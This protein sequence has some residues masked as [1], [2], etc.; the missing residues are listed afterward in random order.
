MF[1]TFLW[2]HSNSK[3]VSYVSWQNR[4]PNL[5]TNCNIKLIVRVIASELLECVWPFVVL[6]LKGW[7]WALQPCVMYMQCIWQI[8][9]FQTFFYFR[10]ALAVIHFSG[11]VTISRGFFQWSSFFKDA[12]LLWNKRLQSLSYW[13]N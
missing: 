12:V 2:V 11:T 4:Y 8:F 3:V 9:I 10:D 6:A 13:I 5:R 7:K 1:A